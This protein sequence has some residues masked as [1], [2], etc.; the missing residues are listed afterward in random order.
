MNDL[1]TVTF[2][3]VKRLRLAGLP[4][5]AA[6]LLNNFRHSCT[7][8]K[9]QLGKEMVSKNNKIINAIKRKNNICHDCGKKATR[10]KCRCEECRQKHNSYQRKR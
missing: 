4:L 9:V 10:N 1:K 2:D 7:K 6:V 8:N 5:E 3:D